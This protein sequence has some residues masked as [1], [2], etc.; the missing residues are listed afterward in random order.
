[1][2]QPRPTPERLIDKAILAVCCLTSFLV[3]QAE[4]ATVGA[5]L[6]AVIVA[7]LGH[8]LPRPARLGLPFAYCAAALAWPPAAG[9]LPVV[10]YDLFA[11][12]SLAARLVPPVP[13]VAAARGWP[14]LGWL[15]SALLCGAGFVLARRTLALEAE[16]ARYRALRDSAREASL[17]LEERNRG[18]VEARDLSVR[19]ARLGE[20]ERIARDIHDNV[21]HLLTRA[22]M[23]VEA[24]KVVHAGEPQIASE[25]DAVS[26]T[27]AQ[28][29]G[30]V[31]DAV[32]DLHDDALNPE[33]LIRAAL[34]GSPFAQTSLAF[35]AP[36]L[37]APAG[38]CFVAIV[39]EAVTNAV[40]HSD[41][42]RMDVAVAE[43]P[44][45]WRLTVQD[46]GSD[47]AGT[48]REAFS[49]RA[50]SGQGAAPGR[51]AHS[52][53]GAVQAGGANPGGK[54][55]GEGRGMGL[56]TMEARVRA[57][58]G[59]LRAGHEGGFRIHATIPRKE[60]T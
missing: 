35:D 59:V 7:A 19:V 25:Y 45:M 40:R 26:A 13:L 46:N 56:E 16:R 51:E 6:A 4:A 29:M 8:L 2:T 39:R 41:A 14:A 57:L 44:G 52:R 34:D 21:G 3:Q 43:Y 60:R 50:A 30:T 47:A 17:A 11:D 18:L 49:G 10:A 48:G 24:L 27:L 32:H 20:R 53:R 33:A 28:A 54:G 37:S 22:I 31:R 38:H 58:G 1:M 42:S 36:N 9:F 55:D 15:A 12:E 23:Q 5:G